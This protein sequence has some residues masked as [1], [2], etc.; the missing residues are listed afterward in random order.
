MATPFTALPSGVDNDTAELIAAVPLTSD[1]E[2]DYWFDLLQAA[3]AAG[4]EDQDLTRF[5]A[6]VRDGA[7]ALDTASVEAFLEAV[8]WA[9]DG[10][11]PVE[12]VL[13]VRPQLPGAYWELYW[14]RYGDA[15]EAQQAETGAAE[16]AAETA[17]PDSGDRFAWVGAEIG[18]RLAQA[19]GSDWRHYL[20]QQ[21][22]PRWGSGWDAHPDDHKL[23]W[24]TDLVG[25]LLSPAEPDSGTV[26]DSGGTPAEE[27]ELDV[28]ALVER[29]VAEAA[30]EVEGAEAL[31]AED[32]S[33]IAATVRQNIAEEMA[34]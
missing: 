16:P 22:D 24:L 6:R 30:S 19:W 14:Q 13:A 2:V 31:S 28:D 23:A 25:E 18:G 3:Y 29:L 27:A 21:L 11:A 4:E 10:L 7:G 5:A 20:G 12:R 15:A 34:E 26:P 17:E 9:G 8:G 32:L 33:E 1:A